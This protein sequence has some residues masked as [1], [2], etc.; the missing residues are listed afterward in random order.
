MLN[1]NRIY[2][3]FMGEAN[4][5]G[6]GS[7]CTFVRLAGCNLRCYSDTLGSSCDTPEALCAKSGKNMREDM[8]LDMCRSLGNNIICVTGGEPLEQ[9][10]HELVYKAVA[11][12]FQV[13]VETNGSKDISSYSG[14]PNLSFVVD[15]KSPSTGMKDMMRES[16]YACMTSWDFLKFVIYDENDYEDALAFY[17]EHEDSA[18]FNFAIGL[19]W[20]AK[21]SYRWLLGRLQYDRFKASVNFQTHKMMVMYDET[22]KDISVINIP[23]NL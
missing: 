15:R 12:G 2:P 18:K 22:K 5:W 7:L 21:V 10:I 4:N 17:R 1:I 3:S 13:V 20:G 11:N 14:I 19:Y 9:D 16:N 8:I 6:I 23:K